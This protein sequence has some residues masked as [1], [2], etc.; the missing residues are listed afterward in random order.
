MSWR[1]SS[2]SRAARRSPEP[3]RRAHRRPRRRGDLSMRPLASA[4]R[5]GR[6]VRARAARPTGSGPMAHGAC[7]R[8]RP[9]W[10]GSDVGI[11]RVR[12]VLLAVDRWIASNG[13]ADEA[14]RRAR[15]ARTCVF[16]V[17]E[18]A[19]P[20]LPGGRS[21]GSTRSA[22]GWPGA[23]A[24]VGRRARPAS[25]AAFLSC[26]RGI[27]RG[28]HARGVGLRRRRCHRARLAPSD[29]HPPPRPPGASHPRCRST[30]PAR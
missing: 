5:G 2:I 23:R 25:R 4:S 8:P 3:P 29:G 20:D 30:L 24:I 11:D 9:C 18:R 10:D 17:V 26:G 22:T 6:R 14:I 21:A 16:S 7:G 13:A 27:P 12:R 28:V 19:Q 1:A 15:M